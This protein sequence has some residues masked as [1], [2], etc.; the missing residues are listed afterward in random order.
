MGPRGSKIG[1]GSSKIDQIRVQNQYVKEVVKK[2]GA[3]FVNVHLINF[4]GQ[5]AMYK[6]QKITKK[7]ITSSGVLAVLSSRGGYCYYHHHHC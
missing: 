4:C 6:V 5:N 7:L 2:Y 3:Q 1:P